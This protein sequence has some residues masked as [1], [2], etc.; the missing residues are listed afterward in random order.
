MIEVLVY[1]PLMNSDEI[2]QKSIVF[3]IFITICIAVVFKCLISGLVSLNVIFKKTNCTLLL[4]VELHHPE[5]D[6]FNS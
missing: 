1:R 5:K 3:R 2:R 4:W 6:T